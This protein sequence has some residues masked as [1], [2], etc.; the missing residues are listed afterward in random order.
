MITKSE[1]DAYSAHGC[2]DYIE[3]DRI[4][5]RRALAQALKTATNNDDRR[6]LCAEMAF[7]EAAHYERLS[8]FD[9][10]DDYARE[11]ALA[12]IEICNLRGTLLLTDCTDEQINDTCLALLRAQNASER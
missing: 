4:Q 5:G 1:Y 2:A 3:A 7:T 8:T 10:I 9:C 11:F 12:K 6:V